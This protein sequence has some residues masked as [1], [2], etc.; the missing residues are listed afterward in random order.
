VNKET[1]KGLIFDSRERLKAIDFVRRD[2][3][4]EYAFLETTGKIAAIRATH[5]GGGGPSLGILIEYPTTTAPASIGGHERTLVVR[6]R[7]QGRT[8]PG[9]AFIGAGNYAT[10]VLAPAFVAAGARLLT[11]ATA[12]GVS[13]VHAARKFG[14]AATTT[15]AGAVFDDPDVAAVVVSTRHDTH[16]DF[17]CRAF[18]AGKHVFVEKPLALTLEELAAIED[19]EARRAEFDMRVQRAYESAKAVNAA[20]GGG[21]DDVIDPAETRSWIV[22]GLQTLPPTAPREGKKYPYIDPW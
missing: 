11:V 13:G 8:D 3:E 6:P 9:V 22:R 12:N 17:V 10:A 20:A 2:L 7:P 21:L 4:L 5:Y 19:P 16:A 1:M 15:D 14:F 18:A